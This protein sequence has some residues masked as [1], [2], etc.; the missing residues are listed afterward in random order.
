MADDDDVSILIDQEEFTA[1]PSVDIHL[2]LDTFASVEFE[3][4]FEKDRREFRDLFRPFS[5]KPVEVRVAA[6][7]SGGGLL[8]AVGLGAAPSNPGRIFNGTLLGIDPDA[9]AEKSV[10]KVSAY[11]LPGV[12]QDCMA[13]ADSTPIEFE[14]LDLREIA[15]SITA[16]YGLELD[17]RAPPGAVFDK[18][19]L[20]VDRRLFDFLAELA[21]Q[22]NIVISSTPEGALLCWQSV[23]GT[24]PVAR[25]RDDEQPV[26]KVSASFSPQTYF[27]E[28]TG[29]ATA[30]K[31]RKGKNARKG[32][33]FTELNPRLTGILRPMSFTLGDT[34]DAGAP[35]ATRAK[36][37]R[38][39]GNMA[40]YAVN[41][42]TWRDPQ[43]DIWRPNTTVTL[44]APD[45][46]VY[47]ESQFL[48]RTVDLHQDAEKSTAV[49]GLVLPGA[50]S[51]TVPEVLPWEE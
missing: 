24:T 8:D 19:K 7:G 39:F 51:G 9:D 48:V 46:M 26:T 40:Q 34:E 42:A 14:G 20:D 22:R 10:V 43:G 38:M 3:A 32:S 4:P 2:A 31:K 23:T 21:K 1:W 18:V 12:L 37:G 13:P 33:R 6:A 5:F 16:A 17:F 29:F 41:V 35:E 28:I 11:S 15:K 50:F 44:L 27:S 47:T 36:L 49:L 45:A 25:L 30:R